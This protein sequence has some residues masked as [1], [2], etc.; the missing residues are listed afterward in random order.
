MNTLGINI[1]S[2][3]VKVVWH[4]DDHV[5]SHIVETHEG[6]VLQTL[7][8]IL[9]RLNL[10]D[11]TKALATGTE[12]RHLLKLKSIIEPLCIEEALKHL[13]YHADAL[14]SL[15]GED[16]VV[17]VIDE[18]QKIITSFSGNK[19]AS[20]TG[21]FFKQQLARMNMKLDDIA[22]VSPES[23]VLKLSSRCSVFMKS[24]CTHRLNKGEAGT[25][26]IV[27]SLSDVMATKVVEFIKKAKITNSKIL[28]TGGVTQNPHLMRFIRE[29]MPENEFIVP[30]QATY[31]EAYGA[32]LL[33]GS[34][35]TPLPALND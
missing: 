29:R 14:V 11:N 18:N 20:G 19:C 33:A 12:G 13:N 1:G 30:E 25:G 32:A 22:S 8:N 27:L 7:E 5:V 31:F 6:N 34:M 9:S 3:S 15:G 2:S 23:R 28:L 4:Q 21:E 35:G 17:Y 10:P 16:L 24:D 26:D